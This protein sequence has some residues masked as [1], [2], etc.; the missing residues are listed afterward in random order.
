MELQFYIHFRRPLYRLTLQY[1]ICIYMFASVRISR[2]VCVCVF[3]VHGIST[4][5]ALVFSYKVYSSWG[6]YIIF[7]CQPCAHLTTPEATAKELL[8]LLLQLL[9]R[10]LLACFS[11]N[12]AKM[13]ASQAPTVREVVGGQLLTL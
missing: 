8:Q 10:A 4:K 13:Q 2:H 9:F 7:K 1:G 6:Y 5:R 3:Q 11:S 12:L